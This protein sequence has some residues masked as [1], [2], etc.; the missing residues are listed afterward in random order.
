MKTNII[1]ENLKCNGCANTIRK[2]VGHLPG[3]ESVEID[4][5]TAC[6]TITH[7]DEA[8]APAVRTKLMHLGYPEIDSVHGVSKLALNARS[9]VSCAVG[10]M[11]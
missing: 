8:V 11:S 7:S 6:V 5:D 4:V 2:D 10:K 9:F 3:V 1:V